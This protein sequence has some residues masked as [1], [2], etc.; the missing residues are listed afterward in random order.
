[1]CEASGS[2]C[3]KWLAMSKTFKHNDGDVRIFEENSTGA[4]RMKRAL[5]RRT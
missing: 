4:T 5:V 3:D 2:W 1:M